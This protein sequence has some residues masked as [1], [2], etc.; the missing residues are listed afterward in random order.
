MR[1]GRL[2]A[3]QSIIPG[4]IIETRTGI[5][6]VARMVDTETS[7]I[8][9]VEDVYGEDKNLPALRSLAEGMAIKFHQDFPLLSG[10][11]I[12]QKGKHIFTDLG[13]DKTKIQRRLIVY[14]EE[15]IKHPVTGKIL[16]SDNVI[17]GRA[18]VTQVMPEMS[19]AELLDAEAGT[20]KPLD[21]V[22]TE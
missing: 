5:E 18:R 10:I 3:A 20:I 11:I 13:Q 9:A 22:I 2:V 14:G 7:E 15:P 19:K 17:K 4:S 12:Q 21:K 6:I 8:L 16:G 1:V